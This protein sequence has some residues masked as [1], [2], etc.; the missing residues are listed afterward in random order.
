MLHVKSLD[1]L[2]VISF[3]LPMLTIV[4]DLSKLTNQ[5]GTD[6]ENKASLRVIDECT[7]PIHLYNVTCS[8]EEDKLVNCSHNKTAPSFSYNNHTCGIFLKCSGKRNLG[9]IAIRIGW[10]YQSLCMHTV[11]RAAC[12]NGD[13]ELYV[14]DQNEPGQGWLLICF[15]KEWRTLCDSEWDFLDS[16]VACRQLGYIGGFHSR[17][18]YHNNK[19]I[20]LIVTLLFSVEL[21]LAGTPKDMY[22]IHADN[23][24]C[25]GNETRLLDCQHSTEHNCIHSR[26][27]FLS[28]KGI[29]KQPCSYSYKHGH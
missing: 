27:V 25:V 22:P 4:N 7:T 1:S 9:F 11:P 26:D 12:K 15:N 21:P 8:G 20:W 17:S 28:C 13:V 19:I 24:R 18:I 16:T 23:V 29:Y 2:L 6:T 10:N 5:S 14:L 3:Q